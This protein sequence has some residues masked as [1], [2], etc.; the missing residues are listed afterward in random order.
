MAEELELPPST[1]AIAV[2]NSTGTGKRS[3]SLK[4]ATGNPQADHDDHV[5]ATVDDRSNTRHSINLSKLNFQ[6]CDV[7]NLG[8][9]LDSRKGNLIHVCRACDLPILIYA[10][11]VR[12]CMD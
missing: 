11:F 10:R 8:S 5:S 1:I 12:E 7:N 6:D 4:L 2:R 9:G 3:I